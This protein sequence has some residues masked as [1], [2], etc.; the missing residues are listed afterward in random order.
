[1]H[2]MTVLP[3]KMAIVSW[4]Q[5]CDITSHYIETLC[6]ELWKNNWTYRFAIWVVD[7][8]GPKEAQVKV[9]LYS[10]GGATVP[11]DTLPWALQNGSSSWFALWDVDSGEPKEAQVQFCSSDGANVPSHQGILAPPGECD[12]TVRLTTCFQY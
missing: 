9:Q 12:L 8:G 3:Y 11:N 2:S 5:V 7:S 4:P 10:P 1:M 6:C